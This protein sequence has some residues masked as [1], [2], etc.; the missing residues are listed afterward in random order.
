MSTVEN[1]S[2]NDL[3]QQQYCEFVNIFEVKLR[4]SHVNIYI[5]HSSLFRF[6]ITPRY[7]PMSLIKI[8]KKIRFYIFVPYDFI[9]FN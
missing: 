2:F 3:N 7:H 6:P 5:R 9:T 4:T 1:G 8:E